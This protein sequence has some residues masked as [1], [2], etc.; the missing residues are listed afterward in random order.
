MGPATTPFPLSG[1]IAWAVIRRMVWAALVVYGVV[2]AMFFLLVLAPDYKYIAAMWGRARQGEVVE[3]QDPPPL[4]EQ[5]VDWMV[6]VFTLQWGG[7]ETALQRGVGEFGGA[8]NFAVIGDALWV[9]AIYAVPATVLAF[10]LAMVLG[11]YAA[12]RPD[13]WLD[14]TFTGSTY[15]AFSV[16]NFFLAAILFYTLRDLQLAWFPAG[17]ETG[18]GLTVDNLVWLAL[19]GFVLVGH[20]VA[21]LFRY[22]RAQVQDALGEQYV[23]LAESKGVGS[24]RVA[25]HVFR[26]AAL[27]MVTLFVSE[28]LGVALVTLF[29]IEAVFEV[30]GIGALAFDAVSNQDVDLIMIL[31]ALFAAVVVFANLLGDLAYLALDPRIDR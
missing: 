10:L 24:L 29:V 2:S 11:Y 8:A 7:S 27:P 22:S 19:P 21:G 5:Y 14:W 3:A 15:L 31:T 1:R 12:R 4:T 18:V 9:T 28:L 20:L 16:P 26:N 17:Y 13:S 30:P 23:Q 6:S 25:R